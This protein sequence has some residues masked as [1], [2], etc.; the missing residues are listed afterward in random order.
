MGIDHVREQLCH[1]LERYLQHP[2]EHGK[3]SVFAS[4][5]TA[6]FYTIRGGRQREKPAVDEEK[7]EP[8]DMCV[9]GSAA[10]SAHIFASAPY[11]PAFFF[12]MEFNFLPQALAPQS[13]QAFARMPYSPAFRLASCFVCVCSGPPLRLAF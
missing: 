11:A 9:L 7:N 10:H 1:W 3:D 13:A 5:A 2:R 6:A 8:V 12:R 4:A